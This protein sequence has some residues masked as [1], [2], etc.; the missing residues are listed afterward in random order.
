[1]PHGNPDLQRVW[2]LFWKKINK[3]TFLNQTFEYEGG[4]LVFLYLFYFF[5]GKNKQKTNESKSENNII[6]IFYGPAKG[7]WGIGNNITI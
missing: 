7:Q 4:Y 2:L 3:K 1:M 6:I 5:G